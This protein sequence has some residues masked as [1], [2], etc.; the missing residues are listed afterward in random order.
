M[1]L[2]EKEDFIQVDYREGEFVTVCISYDLAD[3]E[4]KNDFYVL[5]KFKNNLKECI[6]FTLGAMSSMR[7]FQDKLYKPATCKD[8]TFRESAL[9]Q[10]N[11]NGYSK[12]LEELF[13][14]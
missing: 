10:I 6:G 9:K 12:K 8:I 1:Q 2:Y 13:K 14:K 7:L 4:N 3:S 5:K 11:K